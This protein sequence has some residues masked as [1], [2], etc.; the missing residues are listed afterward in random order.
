MISARV[1]KTPVSVI[2]NENDSNMK[3]VA[4]SIIDQ[5]ILMD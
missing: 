5:W 3:L 2:A 1:G 4:G